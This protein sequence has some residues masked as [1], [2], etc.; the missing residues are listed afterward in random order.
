MCK[1]LTG[2]QTLGVNIILTFKHFNHHCHFHGHRS[3][4]IFFKFNLHH[5]LSIQS[6]KKNQIKYMPD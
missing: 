5:K 2:K 1:L 6:K 4:I 3:F